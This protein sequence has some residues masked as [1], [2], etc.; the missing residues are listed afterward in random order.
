MSV[1]TEVARAPH[2]TVL[3]G[4][5]AGLAVGH[6]A[7][8]RGVPFTVIESSDRPGGLCRTVRRGDFAFDLGA[9]RFH[10]R[11]PDVTRDVLSL[12]GGGMHRVSLGSHI[13]H[14]G[15]LVDFPPSGLNL[16]ATLGPLT[17]ARSVLEMAAARLR[18]P[19][20]H[21][22]FEDAMVRAYGRTLADLFLLNYSSKLWGV[23][24]AQ[25]SP[26]VGGG[27]LKGLTV[28]SALTGA[29]FG[30]AAHANHVDGAFYYPAHG[31][32][33]ITD[34]LAG[35][36]GRA[37][38]RTG[39][40]VTR[41]HHD[42]GAITT[43]DVNGHLCLEVDRLVSTIPL[44]RLVRLL[45]PP[46]PDDVAGDASLLRFRSLRVV[47][48]CIDRPSV[49][50]SATVYFPD[51][52]MPFTRV[53]EPRNRSAVMSPPGQTSLVAEIPCAKTDPAW[54]ESDEALVGATT[55]ALASLL[56]FRPEDVIDSMALRVP[57]A[58]PVL[59]LDGESRAQR[60]RARLE[61]FRNL[62]LTGR[63][64]RFEYAWIHGLLREGRHIVERIA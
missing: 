49:T 14:R 12:T 38:I 46:L 59:D 60:V 7:R 2:V 31:I 43:V 56:G 30:R 50:G 23:S 41:V 18:R 58:Y 5:I 11:D 15:R 62:E 17:V 55:S 20:G 36:C 28:R 35:S 29:I 22:S 19:A 51:R 4:G 47:A 26:R 25:L 8:C 42:G 21:P 61:Q 27:R 9:H 63:G 39:A 33:D 44:P 45:D 34:A 16:I 13:W 32:G 24:C 53:F 6:Y 57:D 37:N 52:A 3:G 10:D 1:S 64:G 40:R 48:L 54:M